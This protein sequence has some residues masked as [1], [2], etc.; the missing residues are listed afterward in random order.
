MG[1]YLLTKQIQFFFWKAHIILIITAAPC[2]YA[3]PGS[4]YVSGK[5]PTYP[6]PKPTLT[7]SFHL[8]QNV[9]LGEG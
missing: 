4:L 1:K 9:D 8:E 2:V 7:L 3:N 6:S 5:L